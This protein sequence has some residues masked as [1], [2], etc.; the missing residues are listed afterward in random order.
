[1]RGSWIGGGLAAFLAIGAAAG[2]ARAEEQPNGP[3]R[4]ASREAAAEGATRSRAI[5]ATQI[6]D[7]RAK[8]IVDALTATAA[9][10]TA[11]IKAEIAVGE[12]L[13]GNVELLPLPPAIVSLV[14]E[15]R[16]FNYAVAHGEVVI[17]QPSSRKA[18]EIIR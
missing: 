16:G 11:G 5:G 18:V 8:R 10:A 6:S 1:M 12:P 2:L 3:D 9:P 13:P 15:F 17:V 7:D 4:S 14:P